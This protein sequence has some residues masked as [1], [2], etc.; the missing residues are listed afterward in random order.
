MASRGDVFAD[1]VSLPKD[2]SALIALDGATGQIQS[3]SDSEL[4]QSYLKALDHRVPG[5]QRL[6]AATLEYTAWQAGGAVATYTV[7]VFS[8]VAVDGVTGDV[9]VHDVFAYL[10]EVFEGGP[11]TVA[12]MEIG[13]DATPDV[14]AYRTSFDVHT[15][16]NNRWILDAATKAAQLKDGTTVRLGL[17]SRLTMTLTVSPTNLT[18]LIRG[19]ISLFVLY[20]HLPALP[21]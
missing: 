15:L 6:Y 1:K 13:E 12:D 9:I 16:P 10:H 7:N 5:A 20:S 4:N 11:I 18:N 3:G 17:G 8:P 2:G 19:R 14:D 21:P